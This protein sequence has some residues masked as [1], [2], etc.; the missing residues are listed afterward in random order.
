MNLLLQH[1]TK[2]SLL[3]MD[4][5]IIFE[6]NLLT[7]LLNDKKKFSFNLINLLNKYIVILPKIGSNRYFPYS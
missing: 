7:K 1:N 5:K 3:L 2:N 4:F 6:R